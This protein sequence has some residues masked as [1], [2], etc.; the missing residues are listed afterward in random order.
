MEIDDQ[1]LDRIIGAAGRQ[2][3]LDMAAFWS[4][5]ELVVTEHHIRSNFGS[6]KIAKERIDRLKMIRKRAWQ[7]ALLLKDDDDDWGMVRLLWPAADGSPLARTEFLIEQLDRLDMLRGAPRDAIRLTE[8]RFNVTDSP[9]TWLAGAR[10]P[11]LFKKH[12]GIEAAVHRNK[13]N[14]PVGAFIGFAN[15]VLI[16]F[17]ITNGGK[18][19][20]LE[21]IIRARTDARSGRRRRKGVGQG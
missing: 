20:E 19:Y 4:D 15:Q 21:S 7:L 10:L 1:I 3:L 5:L 17:G 16:E 6:S 18:P 8:K 14:V 13:D 11:E 9:F 12:F 2:P